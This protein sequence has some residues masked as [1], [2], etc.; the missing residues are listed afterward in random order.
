MAPRKKPTNAVGTHRGKPVLAK[1]IKITNTGDGLSKA[2]AIT[3]VK[4]DDGSEHFISMRLKHTRTYHDNVFSQDDPEKLVGYEEVLQFQAQG[5]VF[6]DRP[7][8]AQQVVEMEER[9]AERAEAEAAAEEKRKRR[10]KGEF[11]IEDSLADAN[12]ATGSDPF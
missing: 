7:D 3:P 1:K 2:M 11:T 5:A 4:I 8:A 10:E 12:E 6:D 9:I